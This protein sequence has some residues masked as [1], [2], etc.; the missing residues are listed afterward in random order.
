MNILFHSNQLAERGTEVSM[1][2]LAYYT[3]YLLGYNCSIAARED[4]DTTALPKF[5]DHFPII[6]YKNFDEVEKYIS[7]NKIDWLYAQKGGRIDGVQSKYCKNFIHVVFQRHEPHGDRYCFIS[8]WLANKLGY[9]S[10]KDFLPYIVSLPPLE[11]CLR[12]QLGIPEDAIVFGRH[13]GYEEFNLSGVHQ[14]IIDALSLNKNVYFLFLN[15]KPFYEHNR[16][17]YLP[18]T[19]DRFQVRKFINTCDYMLHARANGES[20]GL[21]VA[22]FLYC[23]KPVITWELGID[24]NHI[25]MCGNKGIYYKSYDDVLSILTDYPRKLPMEVRSCVKQYSP[26]NVVEKFDSLLK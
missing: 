23:N 15:T 12:E 19:I 26:R 6:L 21:A 18:K 25:E 2:D 13:G 22:E 7:N 4:K 5:K 9:H 10:D 16:I 1:F 8:K 24:S 17:I 11:G 20:F 14:A 3:K